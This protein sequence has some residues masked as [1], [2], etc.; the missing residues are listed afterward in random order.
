MILF[1][2]LTDP[3][4]VLKLDIIAPVLDHI[5]HSHT[6]DIKYHAVNLSKDI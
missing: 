3:K 4:N 5:C 1:E 6:S 2:G